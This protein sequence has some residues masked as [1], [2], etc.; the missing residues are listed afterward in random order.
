MFG[1]Q[2]R[3]Y[4]SYHEGFDKIAAEAPQDEASYE[5]QL[6]NVKLANA[7]VPFIYNE[8]GVTSQTA[9]PIKVA[10][11]LYKEAACTAHGAGK[12]KKK[13]KKATIVKVAAA[14]SVDI[15]LTQTLSDPACASREKV[16][17]TQSFGR[18]Y[19]LELLKDVF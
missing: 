3:N 12:K 5:A 13:V 17:M 9:D 7:V 16:A 4:L 15:A 19:L 6:V 11:A 8:L 1:E 2:L 14:I 18:E 10:V